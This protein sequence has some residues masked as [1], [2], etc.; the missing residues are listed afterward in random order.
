VYLRYNTEG[1]HYCAGQSYTDE[2]R[3][4]R[5]LVLEG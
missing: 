2:V 3:L 1:V 4:V 5:K